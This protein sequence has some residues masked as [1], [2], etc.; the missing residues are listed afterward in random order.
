MTTTQT[1]IRAL[2]LDALVFSQTRLQVERR[3][4]RTKDQISERAESIK[5]VGVLQPI[6]VR[7]VSTVDAE[8]GSD[9]ERYEVA[10]GEGRV[11]SAKEAGLTEIPAIVR[12]LTDEQVEEIQLIENLQRDDVH[13]LVEALGYETLLK[14]G[15]TVDEI[16]AKVGKSKRTVYT[17][18]QLLKLDPATHEAFRSGRLDLSKALLIASLPVAVDQRKAGAEISDMTYQ[19]ARE[20]IERDYMLRLAD[21]PFDTASVDL[22]KNT[23]ACGPCPKRTG[24]QPELFDV[25]KSSA[26]ICTDKRCFQAKG[27]AGAKL[28]LALARSNGQEIITGPEAKKVMPYQHQHYLAGGYVKP[29]EKCWDDPKQRTY[30]QIFGKDYKPTLVQSPYDKGVVVEVVEK[31]AAIKKL[32]DDGVIDKPKASF[33]PDRTKTAKASNKAANDKAQR[34]REIDEEVELRVLNAVREKDGGKLTAELL[35]YLCAHEIC[36]GV[37][38]DDLVEKTLGFVPRAFYTENLKPL[39]KLSDAKIARALIDC[40]YAKE[41]EFEGANPNNL[42]RRTAKR[43][44]ID[45]KKIRAEVQTSLKPPAAPAKASKKKAA[46][47]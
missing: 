31:S 11:L 29:D 32:H 43:L 27:E 19:R 34:E 46:K 3:A 40:I 36:E 12:E 17:R 24:N 45:E 23:P 1:Q 39:D 18:L 41:L 28:K 9:T 35:R 6:L 47:K 25:S 10:A 30:K 42:I 37:Y 21:A 7:D 8:S 33:R 14:H 20:H 4:M 22:V 2:S 16:A 44:K 26:D 13:E 15:R 5:Q 38:D